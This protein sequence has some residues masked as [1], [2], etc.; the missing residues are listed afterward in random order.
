M[1]DQIH[2]DCQDKEEIC[3]SWSES[4]FCDS[5][6]YPQLKNFMQENCRKSCNEC[7]EF[8]EI[9]FNCCKIGN[10]QKSSKTN[11]IK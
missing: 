10:Y 6:I 1:F 2:V 5:I 3:R 7:G 9:S 4:G 8:K 11:Q